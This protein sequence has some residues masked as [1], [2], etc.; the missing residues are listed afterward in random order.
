MPFHG[1]DPLLT[2]AYIA[3]P[4]SRHS[5][6]R[7]HTHTHTHRQNALSR[8]H[9]LKGTCAHTTHVT[10]ADR[11]CATHG[12]N[13]CPRCDSIHQ[14]PRCLFDWQDTVWRVTRAR[15]DEV[16][17][18]LQKQ[19]QQIVYM[20]KTEQVLLFRSVAAL[21]NRNN[22]QECL[23]VFVYARSKHCEAFVSIKNIAYHETHFRHTVTKQFL[24][25][26]SLRFISLFF[27]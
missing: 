8:A 13:E 12:V 24:T 15:A 22:K 11:Y 17:R 10:V 5:I 16:A 27:F 18:V 21:E 26:M 14:L 6:P 20:N 7:L 25:S 3:S 9:T 4:P 2:R 1:D 19:R 23:K